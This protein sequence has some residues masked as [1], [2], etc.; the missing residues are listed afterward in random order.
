MFVPRREELDEG[1]IFSTLG[2]MVDNK[3]GITVDETS[4]PLG[5][6]VSICIVCD[7]L[8]DD[9]TFCIGLHIDDA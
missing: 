6:E 9:H 1:N 2:C 4:P 7:D 8:V 3:K 5:T